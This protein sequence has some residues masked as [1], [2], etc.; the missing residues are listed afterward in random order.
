MEKITK[1]NKIKVLDLRNASQTDIFQ[2]LRALY[3]LQDTHILKIKK[4]FPK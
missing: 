3:S 2:Y 1:R 4:I